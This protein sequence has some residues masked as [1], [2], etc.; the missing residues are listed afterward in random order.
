MKHPH[1]NFILSL[2]S[3]PLVLKCATKIVKIGLQITINT[4]KIFN[5]GFWQICGLYSNV[6]TLVSFSY[7]LVLVLCLFNKIL[8]FF[9][10][11]RW[12]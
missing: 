11:G 1:I 5:F 4:P 10:G 3:I 12:G 6:W 7:F 8:K 9:W 2:H